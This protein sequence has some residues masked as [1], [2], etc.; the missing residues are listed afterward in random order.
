M[1]RLVSIAAGLGLALASPATAAVL[2]FS[3]TFDNTN[4]PAAP[5]GRCPA[6]TVTI[7]N[8][9]PFTATGTSNFGTF[10]ANQSHCLDAGPPIAVGAPD[11]P[12][13]AGLFTY[14][15][16][17]GDTLSGTYTGL[18]S[19]SGTMGVI[20]NIQHFL[21]T[22]GTGLFATAT[23]S[24][25]GTGQ[26]RFA[27]GPPAATLTISRGLIDVGPVPEPASWVLLIAGFA[28]VGA[29]QRGGRKTLAA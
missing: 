5:G 19:N 28:A 18:L 20:D 9:G 16:A 13:Y 11:T 24:F 7:G 25:L 4:A 22:G 12:Y 1:N 21:V 17:G 15:F 29:T 14:S 2:H 26:I 3:G 8:F 23:G 27:G 10:T 6:L